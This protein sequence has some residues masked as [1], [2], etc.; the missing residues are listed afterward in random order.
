MNAP[1]IVLSTFPD[2]ETAERIVGQLVGEQ[3]IACGNLIP[4]AT[5]LYR[6]KGMIERATET[7]AI[8]KTSPERWDTLRERLR[9]L[10]P[11]EVPEL[12]AFPCERWDPAYGAWVH[13]ATGG[14]G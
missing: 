2:V 11:Y 3:L 1:W 14:A 8:L 10:H 6:W 7:V 13:D 5:S 12:V 9:T 4:G